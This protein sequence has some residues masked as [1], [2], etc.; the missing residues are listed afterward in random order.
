[1]KEFKGVWHKVADGDLPK[2]GERVLVS[3]W[4]LDKEIDTSIGFLE[5][6]KFEDG[7][8]K[9]W[10][11]DDDNIFILELDE[12][13]AW[14][15]LPEYEDENL[16]PCQNCKYAYTV[17]TTKSKSFRICRSKTLCARGADCV[18]K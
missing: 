7:V 14:T 9:R 17:S 18:I 16:D 15:E 4:T 13:I 1:M 11:M 3:Y 10:Y 5:E 12:V 8:R 6:Q 2:L